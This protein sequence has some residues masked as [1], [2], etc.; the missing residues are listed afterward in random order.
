MSDFIDLEEVDHDDVKMRLLAQIFSGEV[1]KWLRGFPT[2]SITS[3]QQLERSFLARWEVKNNPLQIPIEYENMKRAPRE[4]IQYF[5][6]RFN[7]VYNSIP[8][9]INDTPGLAL[10][11]YPDGFDTEMVTN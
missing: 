5:S 7:K 3:F 4:T 1:K 9:D 10:L 2:A 11:H 8:A 6:T